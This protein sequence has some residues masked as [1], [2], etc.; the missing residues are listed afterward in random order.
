[1]SKQLMFVVA[2]L[3]LITAGCGRRQGGNPSGIRRDAGPGPDP[4]ETACVG[5]SNELVCSGNT[6]VTCTST[7]Q[8]GATENCGSGAC[9]RGVGCAAC[10]PSS[11]ACD[12][13]DVTSCNASGSGYDV[14]ATCD[15][16]AGEGC[17]ANTGTCVSLCDIALASNSYIGCEYWPTVTGS[18]VSSDFS[19][20]VVV[21]NPQTI[22]ATV[23]IT[24]GGRNVANETL[25][26]G[27]AKAINLPWVAALKEPFDRSGEYASAL[28]TGGAYRLTS[29]VPVTAYQFSPLEYEKRG[30]CADTASDPD[31]TDGQCFSYSNDA[32]LLLPTNVLTQNYIAMARGT[33]FFQRTATDDS[34]TAIP[35]DDTGATTL[36]YSTPGFVTITAVETGE[37]TV[38]STAKTL[39]GAA[40]IGA[41]RV[42]QSQTVAMEAGDVLQILSGTPTSC[43]PISTDVTEV[44]CGSIFLPATCTLRDTYCD[45]GNDYD[46]TGTQITATGKV[47]VIGGHVAAF[48]PANRWAAD[49]LEETMYPLD[50]W[51]RELVVAV[52]KPIA[53]EPNVIRVLSGADN[54]TVSFLPEVHA[55]VTL[56]KGEYVEFE[57]SEDFKVSGSAALLVGQFLVAQNYEGSAESVEGLGDPSMSLAI[58]SEQFRSSYNFLVP[59]TYA[60]NYV[61]IT[62]PEGA[63]VLIDGRPVTDWNIIEHTGFQ[64]AQV[65]LNGGSHSM[66]SALGFGIVVYG[67]G[68]YTSYM[69]PG[70]LDLQVINIF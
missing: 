24:R 17:D 56:N 63:E 60:E 32:S 23:D 35:L 41:F 57:A 22:P 30:E 44:D 14:V 37:V 70:G 13:A 18:Y 48:V 27:E 64:S 42:G 25:A 31:P 21:S 1:M 29:T 55:A 4:I 43:T 66:T 52:T 62:A 46:L 38:T 50:T 19:F 54:N 61:G 51:G 15:A 67:F 2:G 5:H 68:S 36:R 47:Q 3:V 59:S 39:A 6:A 28:V 10:R 11:F 65:E 12:G 58:P 9:V 16:S 7:G 45:V 69:Y 49:H 26:P 40:G 8:N 33:H 34:G 53:E 20:A